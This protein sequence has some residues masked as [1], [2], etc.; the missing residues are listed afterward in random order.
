MKKQ[1]V[2]F[3]AGNEIFLTTYMNLMLRNLRTNNGCQLHGGNFESCNFA[4]HV[5]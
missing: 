1:W 2:F 4:V 5:G 3:E